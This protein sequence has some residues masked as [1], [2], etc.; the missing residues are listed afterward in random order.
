V[1]SFV[2]CI[3]DLVEEVEEVPRLTLTCR[4]GEQKS[5]ENQS[6]ENQRIQLFSRAFP[7]D[8]QD[9]LHKPKVEGLVEYWQMTLKGKGYEVQLAR[10]IERTGAIY[11]NLNKD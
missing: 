3:L 7:R 6:T 1:Q 11:G 5:R 9:S 8:V 4:R 10:E 2:S